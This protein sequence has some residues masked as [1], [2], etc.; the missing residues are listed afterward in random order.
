MRLLA[1]HNSAVLRQAEAHES[2]RAAPHARPAAHR[3]RRPGVVAEAAR[4]GE[5][6]R[7]EH[8]QHPACEAWPPQW[9]AK[10]RMLAAWLAGGLARRR[11]SLSSM[12]PVGGLAR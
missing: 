4:R 7:V 11:P 10:P 8:P 6:A 12:D 2:L 3:R 9:A 1:V 5:V